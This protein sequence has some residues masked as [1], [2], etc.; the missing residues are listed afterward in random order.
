MAHFA[1]MKR[2]LAKL[3]QQALGLEGK[4]LQSLDVSLHLAEDEVVTTK[5]TYVEFIDSN[6]QES[7]TLVHEWVAEQKEV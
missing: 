3:L 4:E 1:S 5:V 7:I 6:Q 2:D